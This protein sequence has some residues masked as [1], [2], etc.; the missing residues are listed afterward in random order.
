MTV[1]INYTAYPFRGLYFFYPTKEFPEMPYN[2]WSQGESTNK[3]K[4]LEGILK[5]ERRD[6]VRRRLKS[7]INTL[8]K[9]DSN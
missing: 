7:A 3:L 6:I 9:L 1:S 5:N 8:K 2:I 4:E